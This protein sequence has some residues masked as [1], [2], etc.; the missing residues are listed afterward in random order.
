MA[1]DI[2]VRTANPTMLDETLRQLPMVAAAVVE[3][4]YDGEAC[5]VR[6]LAG[7]PGFLKFAI[8][9]QGYGEIVEE[10]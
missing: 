3:D 4:S 10:G 9:N 5:T 6:V 1:T 2:R 8:T 7:D